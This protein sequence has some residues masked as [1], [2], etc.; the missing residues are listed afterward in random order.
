MLV[1]DNK[2]SVC[3]LVYAKWA[4]VILLGGGSMLVVACLER[5]HRSR[6]WKKPVS[7]RP[8]S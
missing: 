1:L 3:L 4:L 7:S 6:R 5:T 2:E 8:S